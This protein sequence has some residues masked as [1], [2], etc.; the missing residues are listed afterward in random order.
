MNA[1][2]IKAHPMFG[3]VFVKQFPTQRDGESSAGNEKRL[4]L[5]AA[6]DGNERR[7]YPLPFRK[8]LTPQIVAEC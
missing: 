5:I 7:T 3:W 1:T 2:Q 6:M 8:L 4:L